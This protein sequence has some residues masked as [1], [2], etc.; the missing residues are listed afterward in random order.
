[1]DIVSDHSDRLTR[2]TYTDVGMDST[3]FVMLNLLS[4]SATLLQPMLWANFKRVLQAPTHEVHATITLTRFDAMPQSL[5]G[6]SL[7]SHEN[8]NQ[9][10]CR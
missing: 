10:W 8:L 9:G 4:F 5:A 6:P 3:E 1:M 2:R 7:A